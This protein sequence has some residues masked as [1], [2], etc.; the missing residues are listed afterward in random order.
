[1]N[2]I[3]RSRLFVT[4]ALVFGVAAVAF[5]A[6]PGKGDS[7]AYKTRTFR[8][9]NFDADQAVEIL[10]ELLT[11]PVDVLGPDKGGGRGGPP[12]GDGPPFGNNPGGA[13]PGSR[14]TIL[15]NGPFGFAGPAGAP[16]PGGGVGPVPPRLTGPGQP[17][18]GLPSTGLPL[19][20][21]SG[22]NG[23]YRIMVDERSKSIL[24]RGPESDVKVAVELMALLDLEVDA[25]V[26]AN[27][28][29]LRGY[30]LKEADAENVAESLQ[31]LGTKAKIV[32]VPSLKLVL[33]T[34]PEEDLKDVGEA[35]RALDTAD[36]AKPKLPRK[37]GDETET[38]KLRPKNE[39]P[40]YPRPK[41]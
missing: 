9:K 6:P 7:Q 31:N 40:N 19:P 39:G 12:F 10:E 32:A 36:E 24:M 25:P 27:L 28:A 23:R 22:G 35:V 16:P 18:P 38:K 17:N 33:A 21:G 1:M 37:V 29:A 3:S 15:G 11:E 20:G 34:G 2:P 4:L 41:D 30:R 13:G 14:P 8:L 26:P 5:A